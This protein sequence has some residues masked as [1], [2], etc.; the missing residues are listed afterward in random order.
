MKNGRGVPAQAEVPTWVPAS[1]LRYVTLT[2]AGVNTPVTRMKALS[3]RFPWVEWAVLYSPDRA[4]KEARYP[5]FEWLQAFALTAKRSGMNVALHLCGT[6]VQQLLEVTGSDRPY[7]DTPLK[8]LLELAQSFGRVQLNVRGDVGDAPAFQRGIECISR[9]EERT[10]VVLQWNEHNAALCKWLW[11]QEGFEVL[12]DSSAGRGIERTE[13][14]EPGMDDLRR[15]GFAGGLGPHNLEAQLPL[16]HEAAKRRVYTID[17]EGRIR[18]DADELDLAKCETVLQLSDAFARGQVAQDGAAHG[19]GV[20]QVKSLDG[21]WLDWWVGAARQANMVVPPTDFVRAMYLYRPTGKFESYAPHDDE[22]EALRIIEDEDVHVE[23]GP[24]RTWIA[25]ASTEGPSFE[26]KSF[27]TAG[28]RAVV[29]KHF[30]TTVP[31]DPSQA[32]A[33]PAA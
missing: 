26:S 22:R 3:K 14:H 28:L 17:M 31:K 29:A 30:G 13:W 24:N 25:R 33:L 20:R 19:K 21:K 8:P 18:S 11:L 1:L 32:R 4:G 7:A 27:A 10:R 23:S 16:I 2:G 5:T 6:A 15:V 12:L 9:C